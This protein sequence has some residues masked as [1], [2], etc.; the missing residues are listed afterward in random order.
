MRVRVNVYVGDFM[1]VDGGV[2]AFLV[3]RYEVPIGVDRYLIAVGFRWDDLFRERVTNRPN[4]HV[5][6]RPPGFNRVLGRLGRDLN[7]L[8][9]ETGIGQF[10]VLRLSFVGMLS[11][12]RVATR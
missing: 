2:C 7:L 4:Y 11:G 8:H 6:V 3:I 10:S 12:V 1:P 9:A 5:P